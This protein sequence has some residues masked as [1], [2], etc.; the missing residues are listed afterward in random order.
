MKPLKTFCTIFFVVS[1]RKINKKSEIPVFIRDHSIFEG[2][3]K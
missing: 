2:P 1:S 3:N